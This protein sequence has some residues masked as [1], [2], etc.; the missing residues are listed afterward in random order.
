MDGFYS[1]MILVWP[2]EKIS[3]EKRAT[4]QLLAE[5]SKDEQSFLAM[6]SYSWCN[7]F[8]FDE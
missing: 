5:N 3:R 4:L 7:V 6:Q 1:Q 2:N 8:N